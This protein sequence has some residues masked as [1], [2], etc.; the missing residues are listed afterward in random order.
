M[1]VGNGEKDVGVGN[2]IV[3]DSEWKELVSK[4]IMY[5]DHVFIMPFPSKGILWEIDEIINNS[6]YLDKTLFL[7]PPALHIL[8]DRDKNWSE[9]QSLLNFKG[10]H[11]P[12]YSKK[13]CIAK[14]AKSDKRPITFWEYLNQKILANEVN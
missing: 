13:G 1:C 12:N 3:P 8:G 14:F 5:A 4:L 11:L 9:V 7:M 6:D 2:I 10:Y